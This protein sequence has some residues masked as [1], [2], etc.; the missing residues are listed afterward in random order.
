MA[1]IRET[2]V[3]PDVEG[4]VVER[5][6]VTERPVVI[7]RPVKKKGGFGWGMLLGVLI[8]AGAIVAFAYNQGSFQTA[9]VRADQATQTAR[10]E[11]SQTAD[12]A[13][14][15]VNNATERDSSQP[16]QSN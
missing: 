13:R 14:Q 2:R 1:V 5:N 4:D 10:V 8:V 3:T 15:A 12:N 7:E 9:G 16:T 11:A 6:T